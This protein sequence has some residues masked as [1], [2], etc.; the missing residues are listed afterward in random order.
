MEVVLCVLGNLFGGQGLGNFYQCNKI[1]SVPYN[2]GI[3]FISILL[4]SCN[5]WK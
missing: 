1:V 4:H 2:S 5:V 3:F